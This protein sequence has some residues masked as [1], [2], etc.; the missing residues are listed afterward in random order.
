MRRRLFEQLASIARRVLPARTKRWL[1]RFWDPNQQL[2]GPEALLVRRARAADAE[3]GMP[4][5]ASF[6]VICFAVFDWTFRYQRPQQLMA[7]LG[8][9]G[10][11]VFYLVPVQ[12]SSRRIGVRRVAPNVWEVELPHEGRVERFEGGWTA[13]QT[14]RLMEGL[15]SLRRECDIACAVAIVQ[16]PTWADLAIAASSAFAWPVIYDCMDDWSS[17]ERVGGKIGED[18]QRLARAAAAI[19]ASSEALRERWAGSRVTLMRNACDYEQFA[20]A[21]SEGLLSDVQRPVI[22]YYGAIAEWFDAALMR[23]VAAA[24]PGYT[25]V[26]VGDVRNADAAALA[27]LP[28][29]RLLGEKPYE[30]MPA[31][32]A[33]FDVCLIPFR[34]TPLTRATDP[35][36]LYEYFSQ[37]KPV[38]ATP[39]PELERHEPLVTLAADSV[40][41]A[42]AIDASASE[43][44]DVPVRRIEIARA[45]TWRDRGRTLEELCASVSPLA[46][47]VVVTYN[48]LDYTRL[49]L[50]SIRANTFSPR[51]EVIVVDNASSDGTREY[52]QQLAGVRVIL[53]E[54]NEGF[55]RANNQGVAASSGH[56]VVLLNNDTV[57][58]R[59]WSCRLLR[60]LQDRGIGMVVAVTNYSGNESRIDV[61]YGDLDGMDAFASRRAASHD[62]AHFDIGVAAMYC[63]AMRREVFDRIGPLDERF[64]IG[65]FEDDDYSQRVREAG[66]RVVCAED[67]FVHH[68]GQASFRKLS[69][70]EYFALF[71]RNRKL[72]EEKWGREWVPHQERPRER[73]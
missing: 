67:A 16:L 56:H 62:G 39:L 26:F 15:Q 22:G 57:V 28:N 46:S 3:G 49:C 72:F 33:E 71:E 5:A 17:F 38:V 64:T 18:E 44:A 23:E 6:D 59:G 37:G 36:K 53:N 24:R 40:S 69:Q 1:K 54:E 13:E 66:L 41:F 11:R 58:P 10:H 63:V 55:A 30:L 51:Y 29:V 68:F 48:N 8:R 47:I 45:N 20:T 70:S 7:E 65:M 73:T 35:V 34:V 4:P 60:H 9:R 43:S 42:A 21:H 27:K 52:L 61:D 50:D 31:Y 14:Q 25:F 2:S 32:L 19:T 12:S